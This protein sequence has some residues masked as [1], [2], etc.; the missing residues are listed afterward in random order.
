MTI[1]LGSLL[2]ILTAL[3]VALMGVYTKKIGTDLPTSML[4]FFRFLISFIVILPFIIK[5]K[6]FTF[7]VD[8]P[9]HLSTRVMSALL[10]IFFLLYSIKYIPLVDALLLNN[11][12][13]I[14]IPIFAFCILKAKTPFKAITGIIIGFVGVV[15]ILNPGKEVISL[16][17]I[18]ALLSGIFTAIAIVEIRIISKKNGAMQMLFYYYGVSLVISGIYAAIGWKLPTSGALWLDLVLVGTFGTLYQF[19]ATLTYKTAPVRLMSP[20]LFTAAIF[21]GIFDWQFWGMVPGILTYIGGSLI[22]LGSIITILL[23]RKFII[24]S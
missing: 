15:L 13:S 8:H 21:G 23:G 16:A 14:F 20:L 5:S 9:M 12:A 19:F 2:A 11:T 18:F 1:L 4:L 24:K 17:S 22:I 10:A 7:K 6:K 3:F